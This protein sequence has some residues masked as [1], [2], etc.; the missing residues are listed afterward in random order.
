MSY[1]RCS[2][3]G[4]LAFE[5]RVDK[6]DG[7]PRWHCFCPT[8]RRRAKRDGSV[9]DVDGYGRTLVAA[10]EDLNERKANF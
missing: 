5:S 2:C 8:C 1:P 4:A 10:V 7:G 3:G 6:K 9:I